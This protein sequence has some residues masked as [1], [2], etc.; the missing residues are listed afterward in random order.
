METQPEVTIGIPVYNVKDRISATLESALQQTF[1]SI[2][3]LL[4][5][6]CGTDG[7]IDIVKEYQQNH[8]RGK[9]IRI[10]RQP[11]NMGIGAARNKIIDEA[12]G[13]YLYFLDADDTIHNYTI[14]LLHR[15]ALRYHAVLVYGSRRHSILG[16][17]ESGAVVYSY[18]F[19]V[20]T[21]PNEY[22][23][24]AFHDGIQ[25]QNW[26]YLILIDILRRNNLRVAPVGH[27][28]G[29]DF[30]F[31]VD[32]PTYVTRVVLLPDI[33]YEYYIEEDVFHG[34]RR[35]KA[36]SRQQM[37]LALQTLEEK[38]K[39]EGLRR[40]PWFAKRCAVLL[41]YE[42]SFIREILSRPGQADPP[43]TDRELRD[44]MWHPMTFWQ[45]LGN[46]DARMNN[47]Y[48]WLLGVLPP[49]L[50][51]MVMRKVMKL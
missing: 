37:D 28:Y 47:L 9:D 33:T 45:I 10:V 32:L 17:G 51:V 36:L 19:H 14:A 29:E 40:R 25:A 22:A 42:H 30:T 5:D 35:H 50:S 44:L 24:Y 48:Y 2:E 7:S 38:K 31:T 46:S 49:R 27:G 1:E 3:F 8:P 13:K 20:F 16:D 21:R 23:W 15:A 6:D 4:C 26:N 12:R 11:H 34:K 43:Y 39:R 18:P 41:M